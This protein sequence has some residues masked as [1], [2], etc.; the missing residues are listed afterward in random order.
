MINR[1][2]TLGR[3]LGL[4]DVDSPTVETVLVSILNANENVAAL[5]AGRIFPNAIPQKEIMPAIVYQQISGRLDYA[6]DGAT[7]LSSPRVQLV[8]WDDTYAGAKTLAKAVES[9]LSGY[10]GIVDDI[11]IQGIF[12]IDEGDMPELN[13]SEEGLRRYG[14]RQDYEIWNCEV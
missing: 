11:Q 8:C 7:G 4:L 14:I 5:I 3:V 10:T 9:A 2:G 12:K 1:I 6:N 13:N